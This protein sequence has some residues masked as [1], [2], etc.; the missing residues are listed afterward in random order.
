MVPAESMA[1]FQAFS[2]LRR[3]YVTVDDPLRVTGIL[4]KLQRPTED[5]DAEEI[6]K[7]GEGLAFFDVVYVDHET[8]GAF[9]SGKNATLMPAESM[10]N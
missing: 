6:K 9:L 2:L 10:T 4:G 7:K 3:C 1:V 5:C 8:L